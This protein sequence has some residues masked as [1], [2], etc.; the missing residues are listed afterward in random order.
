MGDADGDSYTIWEYDDSINQEILSLYNINDELRVRIKTIKDNK[1]RITEQSYFN[2]NNEYLELERG[3]SG[4]I[5][6]YDDD[7]NKKIVSFIDSKGE[8]CNNKDGFAH[9]ISW[10]D[11]IGRLIAQKDVTIDGNV[12]GLIG[13]REFIDS[14]KRECA[15]YIHR[16]DDQGH[17]I[18][19]EN[20][21]VFEY[22]EEDN[23][24]RP[25]KNLYLNADKFPLPDTDGDY[26]LSY[27]YDDEKRLSIT[28]CLDE[29]GQPHNNKLGFGIMHSYKNEEGK[30]IKRMYYTIEGTPI[31][32]SG[33]LGCYGLS[34]EYPNEHNKIVG[35]LNEDGE[36]TTNIHGYAYREECFNPETGVNRIFYYDK[37]RNNTQ[38]LEDEN[39]E[40]GYAIYFDNNWRYIDSLGKDGQVA[41]NAAWYSRKA[42]LYEDGKL[43]FYKF[44][45][46]NNKPIAD[47]LGNF[48]TEI[49][50]SD[51]GSMFRLISL[52]EKYDRHLNDYGYC[53]CDV[54]TDITGEQFRIWR[55][56]DN[57]QVLPKLHLG[58]KIKRWLTNF[59]KKDSQ[60][61]IFNC[62][63]IGAVFD[64]VLGNIE[65]NGHGKKQGLHGTYVILQYNDWCFGDEPEKLGE[66]IA[67]TAKQSKHLVLLPVVLNGSLLKDIGDI[68]E[69]NFPAG[70]IG[71]RFREWGINIDTLRI[72]IEKKKEWDKGK[73]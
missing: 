67:N 25:I 45:D 70:Q 73:S 20:G 56:M 37:D 13:F 41:N 50:H 15:Y 61:T 22:F 53:F 46:A 31:T 40:Y 10:Y 43:R 55:D 60:T 17:T 63:Q 54:I 26:G 11:S 58:K 38:S 52:N 18:P 65:G 3:Y 49:L 30:E 4:E 1:N 33:L 9:R 24:G 66:L 42:E 39:K 68:M 36:I 21:S 35:Y 69:F 19:N 2:S 71:L 14:D 72:I 34:Y 44:I 6:E 27:E 28:I 29:S 23:K 5:Y 32:L 62:R 48:G 59:K 51:D 64:C 57:N 16:E 12:H 8:V 47:N 7:E